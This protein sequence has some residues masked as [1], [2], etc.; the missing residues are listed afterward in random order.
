MHAPLLR[1]LRG[2]TPVKAAARAGLI[3]RGV[4]YLLLAA[5]AARLLVGAPGT[6][7]QANANGALSEVAT[8]GLGLALLAA[9]AVGFAAFGVVRLAG[10][11][12][13]DRERRLRRL[14]T[15]GQGIVYL[16]CAAATTS[17]LLGRHA[18]GS[19]QQQRRTARSVLEL[20]G[21]RVLLVA[22]GLVVLAVCCWQL[23]VAVKGHY[24]DTL[25]A[26]QMS[27]LVRRL[28]AATARIGIP[29]RALAFAPVGVFLVL[30][31]L[32]SDARQ[33]KGLDGLLLELTRT[34]WGR[35]AVAVTAGG[36]VAFAAYSFLEARY[37][38]V[39]AG[40]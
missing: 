4:F 23:T 13:D 31:G 24:A 25:H 28:T 9:V 39:S 33:A 2:S 3:G 22:A 20:P 11:A 29:A 21:G 10:A 26:E 12:T 14:S 34:G 15:A 16:G 19:E 27:P 8:S 6:G 36:F 32:R 38:Q 30:A 35:V 5:L 37:R 18:T 7:R 40:A 1:R 17:F